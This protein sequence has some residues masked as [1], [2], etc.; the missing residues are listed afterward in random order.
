MKSIAFLQESLLRKIK[1]KETVKEWNKPKRLLERRADC[2]L[3]VA[4]MSSSSA[5]T[6]LSRS[7]EKRHNCFDF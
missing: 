2:L 6:R 4:S 7:A 1:Q 3:K 5:K